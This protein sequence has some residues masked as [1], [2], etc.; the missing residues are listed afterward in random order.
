MSLESRLSALVS[1]IGADIKALFAGKQDA[2]VSGVNIKTVN[3]ASV[4]GAG[5]LV[6]T[7]ELDPD[8]LALIYEG[9]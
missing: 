8:I 5:D 7:A 9:L 6:I 3:G 2:L 4:I 1:A